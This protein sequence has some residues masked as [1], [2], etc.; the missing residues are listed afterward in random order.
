MGGFAPVPGQ[1]AYGASK[2]AVK[3]LSEGLQGEL[4]DTS[5]RLTLA[6]P[7]AID[8]NI[9]RNSDVVMPSNSEAMRKRIL[10]ADRAAKIILDAVERDRRRVMV[11]IDAWILD[12]L[13]R[14]APVTAAWALAKL[15]KY[16]LQPGE[17]K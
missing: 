1:T 15:I 10:S 5:V 11:G 6:F 2:A 9:M 16:F 17:S 4:A 7:G 14:I 3:L 13:C 8:T 12:F